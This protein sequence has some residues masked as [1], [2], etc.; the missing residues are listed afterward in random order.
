MTSPRRRYQFAWQRRHVAILLAVSVLACA[1]L[2][3]EA[4][5]RQ[6]F[7][8]GPAIFTDRAEASVERIDPN[9]ASS[10]SLQRLSLIGPAKAQAI[11]DYRD[12]HGDRPFAEPEDLQ[13]VKGI[14]EGIVRRVRGHLTFGTGGQRPLNPQPAGP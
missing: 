8:A 3:A 6:W 1:V 4:V 2:G 9:V 10:A 5:G 11:I 13:A 7:D 12:T 14:G